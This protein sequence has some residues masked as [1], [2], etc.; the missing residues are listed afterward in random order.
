MAAYTVESNVDILAI[1][2]HCIHFEDGD[3]VRR[4]ELGKGWLLLAASASP[5][6]V[7]GVGFIVSPRVRHAIDS[8]NMIS[9]RILHLQ[10]LS[11]GQLKTVMFSIYSPTSSSDLREADFFYHCLSDAI[12][13]TPR[14]HMLL[15]CG[16][17]NAT[18]A[19]GDAGSK[20]CPRQRLNRNRDLLRD[21]A[22]GADLVA[23]NTQF[24]KPRYHY[25]HLLWT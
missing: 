7:G 21:L 23:V 15:V 16:D 10:L 25:S 19:P 11:G 24:Q 12:V 5:T 4:F 20:H 14:H 22:D 3:P 13:A 6:G 1:Q 9:P 2:E 8:Y 17:F 18:L